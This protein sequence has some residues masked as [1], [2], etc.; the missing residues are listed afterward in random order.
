MASL[1]SLADIDEVR[2][3]KRRAHWMLLARRA[4]TV[5]QTDAA[6]YLGYKAGTAITNME[7]GRKDPTAIEMQKLAQLYGVPVGMFADPEP[8]DEEKVIQARAV[9]ARAAIELAAEDRAAEE[10]PRQTVDGRPSARR[11]RRSA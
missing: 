6:A 9:L 2:A 10:A 4:A 1:G 11:D 8:T 5:K 7:K 3:R